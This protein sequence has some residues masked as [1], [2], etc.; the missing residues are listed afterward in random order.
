MSNSYT[1]TNTTTFTATHAR[2]I[3]AKVATDLKR[4]QR[5]YGQPNDKWI[6]VFEQEAVILLK[7][8]CLET[9]AYGFLR[10]GIWIKPT[11]IYTARSLEGTS[12]ADH[13]PGRVLPGADVS[14]ADFYS[15]LTYSLVWE[16]MS[17]EE[18][19]ILEDQLPVKRSFASKPSVNG[20]LVSDKTYSAGDY[21]L[22][23]F[24]LRN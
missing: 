9:V 13:D 20:D 4:I 5:F 19:K 3:S 16:H 2:H 12:S 21:A 10:D 15:Y 11:I 14:D 1:T 18:K 23:R 24:S 7:N 8:K 6:A 17:W 22:D